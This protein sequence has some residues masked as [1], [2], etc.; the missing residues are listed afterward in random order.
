MSCTGVRPGRILWWRFVAVCLALSAGLALAQEPIALSGTLKKAKETGALTIGY[1]ESSLPFSYLNQ[2]RRPIGYS[3]EI[4]KAIVQ[5]AGNEV[6]RDLAINWVPVTSETRMEA[7]T[8]GKIDLECGSTT[9]NAERQQRVSFSP[10]I[11]VAG[12]KLLVPHGSPIRTFRD[13]KGKTVVATAGTTNADAIER[14]S[15][16]FNLGITLIRARDHADAFEVL[17]HGGADAYAGDDVLLYGFLAKYGLG[18]KYDVTRD[19]LSYDP[20]GIMLRKD[21]PQ[22]AAVVDKAVRDLIT[23]GELERLY[24][25]WFVD[26][27]PTGE[28][29]GI[30]MSSQLEDIIESTPQQPE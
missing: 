18:K 7:M 10:V 28:R 12:T 26:R 30:P 15:T 29:L 8:S 27:L 22:F 21:D 25:Q 24:K 4:C 17:R 14:L 6:G 23:T 16:R 9:R 2:I 13:L 11:F 3:I 5:T 20:Y 1:R 19:F